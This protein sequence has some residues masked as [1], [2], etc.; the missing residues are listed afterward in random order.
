MNTQAFE[1]VLAPEPQAQ[2]HPPNPIVRDI[3]AFL[4]ERRLQPG[5]RLPA[6]RALAE[7]LGVGRNALREALATLITLRV[8]EA[9]PNSGIYLRRIS[10]ESSF[11]TLGM[12]A[13]MGVNPTP[14]EILETME[15]RAALELLAVRL[16][17]ERRE[18]P[19]LA[20]LRTVLAQTDRE[21][22]EGLNIHASD[23]AFHLALLEA[24]HNEVLVR[25]LNSFYR[26]SA[27]RRKA[28]FINAAQGRATA[29][30]HHKLYEALVARD[31]ATAQDLIQRHMERAR[32]YWK[33]VLGA[34]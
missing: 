28:M 34:E 17:C 1:R 8:I 13:D 2:E 32:T 29:R 14:K 25:V 33:E 23:T 6:E 15:V 4:Q 24:T 11:E 27:A 16:A 12:L 31:V 3:L 10:T 19:D 30:E 18:E 9:R 5:D 20:R 26:F 22:R 7:R 21:L